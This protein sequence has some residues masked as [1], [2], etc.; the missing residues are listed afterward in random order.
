MKKY[1]MLGC[2]SGLLFGDIGDGAERS[3]DVMRAINS[4][5]CGFIEKHRRHSRTR[6]R[7]NLLYKAAEVVM[8]RAAAA[9]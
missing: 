9:G 5:R 1:R 3:N 4:R 2:R 8:C 6:T 7:T